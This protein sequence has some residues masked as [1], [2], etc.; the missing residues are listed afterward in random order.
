MFESAIITRLQSDA[1]FAGYLSTFGGKPSVFSDFAP[2]KAAR[3][4]AVVTIRKQND[5]AVI[6]RFTVMV[7][8]YDMNTSRARM[9]NAAM[10]IECLLDRTHM[11]HERFK[12]IRLFYENSGEVFNAD[13]RDIHYN[14]M[15]SAHAGRAKFVDNLINPATTTPGP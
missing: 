7:D 6:D 12:T 15:F 9:R 4:F 5:S 14:L 2:E 11:E 10:R 8:Y 3:P 13:R 1:E